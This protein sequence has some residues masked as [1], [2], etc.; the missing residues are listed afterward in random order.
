[1]EPPRTGFFGGGPTNDT[2]SDLLW[3]PVSYVF[4][5]LGSFSHFSL[6]KYPFFFDFPKT[7]QHGKTNTCSVGIEEVLYVGSKCPFLPIHDLQYVILEDTT[8]LDL[9]TGGDEDI[10]H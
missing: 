8:G 2:D 3:K 4:K 7:E 5:K 10:L 6:K 1:M 9:I